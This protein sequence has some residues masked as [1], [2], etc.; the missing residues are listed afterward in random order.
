MILTITQEEISI[1]TILITRIIN[2]TSSATEITTTNTTNI[3]TISR[4]D[5]RDI[6]TLGDDV[7]ILAIFA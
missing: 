7:S 4:I 3:I 5:I 1:M 6:I 2:T